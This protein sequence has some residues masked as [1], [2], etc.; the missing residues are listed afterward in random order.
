[1]WAKYGCTHTVYLWSWLNFKKCLSFF[2][3]T[4]VFFVSY[5][6]SNTLSEKNKHRNQKSFFLRYI[7]VQECIFNRINTTATMT[8]REFINN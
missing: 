3:R 5:L 1:M 7:V 8:L 4:S 6:Y 2:V